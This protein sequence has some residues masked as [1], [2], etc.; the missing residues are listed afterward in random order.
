M[1]RWKRS[2]NPRPID[3]DNQIGAIV[4]STHPY[5]S[6]AYYA[7]GGLDLTGEHTSLDAQVTFDAEEDVNNG[8]GVDAFSDP[9]VGF[10]EVAESMGV[11]AAEAYAE[12]KNE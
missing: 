11:E 1:K 8:C 6:F 4:E 2:I 5:R 7:R 3:K 9:T 12:H 10:F